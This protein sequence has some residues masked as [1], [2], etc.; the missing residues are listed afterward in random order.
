MRPLF[1]VGDYIDEVFPAYIWFFPLRRTY[2]IL[3]VGLELFG[4]NEL[5]IL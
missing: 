1:Y 3:D 2:A 5:V 4:S